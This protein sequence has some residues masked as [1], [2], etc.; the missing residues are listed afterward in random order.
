MD[1]NYWV[2][3]RRDYT[4]GLSVIQQKVPVM[5]EVGGRFVSINSWVG[6]DA[7]I[8]DKTCKLTIYAQL[9]DGYTAGDNSLG[10]KIVSKILR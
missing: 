7:L 10:E 6:A 8:K 5:S 3:V 4:N 1:Y 9:T 2:Q